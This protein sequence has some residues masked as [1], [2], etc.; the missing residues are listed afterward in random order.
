MLSFVSF[1]RVI[2]HTQP[3]IGERLLFD[4]YE[5]DVHAGE[6]AQARLKTAFARPAAFRV[7][8]ILLERAGE[9]VTR[10]EEIQ[11]RIWPANTFVDFDHRLHNA[12]ARIRE[13]L[14][15]S[16]E[17]PRY[18]ETVPRRGYRYIGPVQDF[19]HA[20][21]GRGEPAALRL[22]R[23]DHSP[24]TD[25]EPDSLRS[26]RSVVTRV[27]CL[28]NVAVL[29]TPKAA[30]PPV[31]SIAVLPLKN[32]SGDASEEFFVDGMTDQLITDLAKVGSL[33]AIARTSLQCRT[34]GPRR[35]CPEV[36]KA[37][38]EGRRPSLKDRHVPVR[39]NE[40]RVTAQ[41]IQA[42]TSTS[43]FGQRPASTGARSIAQI[44]SAEVGERHRADRF[45]HNSLPRSRLT[46]RLGSLR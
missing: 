42:S 24:K 44:L 19:S 2:W 33:R 30:G 14:G 36:A 21:L 32:F 1:P 9:V 45:A 20:A 16:A 26:L 28:V 13:V 34:N 39:A 35:A 12:I 38:I 3:R 41:L 23:H 11:S 22:N 17:T 31:R 6:L 5:L 25:A 4:G 27:G 37:R 15:D 7:L 29:S 8:E 10:K 43:T 18:L 40:L 46:L